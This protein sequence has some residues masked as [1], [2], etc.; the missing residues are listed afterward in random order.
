MEAYSQGVTVHSVGNYREGLLHNRPVQGL[1][2]PT[3][4]LKCSLVCWNGKMRSVIQLMHGVYH[5]DEFKC[6]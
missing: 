5:T 1:R 3:L 6:E 2:L 4:G